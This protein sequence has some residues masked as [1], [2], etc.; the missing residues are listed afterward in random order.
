[1]PPRPCWRPHNAKISNP[2]IGVVAA[3]PVSS[4]R[5]LTGTQS[6]DRDRGQMVRGKLIPPL[7]SAAGKH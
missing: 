7:P 4:S 2:V 1:M 5:R 6:H 3:F